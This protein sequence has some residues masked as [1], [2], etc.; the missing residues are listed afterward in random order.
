MPRPIP[1]PAPVTNMTLSFKDMIFSYRKSANPSQVGM[2]PFGQYS[3]GK[4]DYTP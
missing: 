3:Q 4:T 2:F 1:W